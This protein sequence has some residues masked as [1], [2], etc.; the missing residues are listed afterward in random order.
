MDESWKKC[1]L[2]A[3][4]SFSFFI[5]PRYYYR[6]TVERVGLMQND[7]R[8]KPVLDI[9]KGKL[10]IN[11]KRNSMGGISKYTFQ[12]FNRMIHKEGESLRRTNLLPSIFYSTSSFY[13][14]PIIMNTSRLNQINAKIRTF[15]FLFTPPTH[16]KGSYY[17]GIIRTQKHF[18]L[19]TKR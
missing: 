7:E 19:C 17:Q 2:R 16:G 1:I 12:R 5:I 3:E 10:N 4:I 11:L 9:Y 13:A 6:S 8:H 14:L 18:N 15:I